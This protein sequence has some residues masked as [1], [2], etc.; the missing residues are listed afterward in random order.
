[1]NERVFR[2]IP[3]LKSILQSIGDLGRRLFGRREG[4]DTRVS[5]QEAKPGSSTVSRDALSTLTGVPIRDLS[6]FERSLTHRSILRGSPDSHLASNERLEFLGD[7]VLGFVVAEYLYNF[8][9]DKDEGF[10]TRLRAK[11]VNGQAL[12]SCAKRIGLGNHVLMSG[13]M[14]QSGG[15]ENQTILADA[16]EAVIGAIYL[17]AGMEAASRFIHKNLLSEIDLVELAERHDNYK[18]LL[19]EHAQAQGWPQ[20]EYRITMEEGPSHDKVFTVEVVVKNMPYGR[21]T[22]G[23]KKKA[24]QKAAREALRHLRRE[25]T[26]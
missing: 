5:E 9:P 23:S 16:F 26:A 12:A 4:S 19:L 17:D 20:P 24:E 13:N 18:S 10:L 14:E 15:R 8:F 3:V 21:G 1:M 7:A 25:E 6:L 2:P 11:L 22:A